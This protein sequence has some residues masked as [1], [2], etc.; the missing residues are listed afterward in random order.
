MK[1]ISSN[2]IRVLKKALNKYVKEMYGYVYTNLTNKKIVKH[3]NVYKKNNKY[4][5]YL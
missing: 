1:K 4:Y 5:T 2:S 3:F